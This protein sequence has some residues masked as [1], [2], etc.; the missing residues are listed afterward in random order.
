MKSKQTKS[1][2]ADV[3]HRVTALLRD[4]ANNPDAG[5][6]YSDPGT[7]RADL[8]TLEA[9][10]ADNSPQRLAVVLDGGLVQAV[11]GE[12]V[13]VD[14]EVAIIDYDTLGAEDSDLMS[15]HQ[16]DGS[17][18]EAVVALQSIERPGIDL[19]SVFN[20]PDVPATPL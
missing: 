7:M 5:F 8:E 19:N 20:Q 6:A 9:I 3:L 17:T 14:L 13:P 10:V 15:V 1:V 4:Y 18:A 2:P 16:S 11:V 12:N